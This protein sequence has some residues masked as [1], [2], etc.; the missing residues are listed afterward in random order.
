[1]SSEEQT[2]DPSQFEDEADEMMQ[3]VVDGVANYGAEKVIRALSD[4]CYIAAAVHEE[5]KDWSRMAELLHYAK[6][7]EE[8]PLHRK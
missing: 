3:Q 6:R 1:M 2:Q 5:L 8:M 7:L 4:A